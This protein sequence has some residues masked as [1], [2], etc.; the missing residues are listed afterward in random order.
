MKHCHNTANEIDN[1]TKTSCCNRQL[2]NDD[3]R[4]FKC[5]TCC[6]I[7]TSYTTKSKEEKKLVRKINWILMPFIFLLV[8]IQVGQ[9][10]MILQVLTL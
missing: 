2:Q 9:Q 5:A 10:P 3:T 4:H 7:N 8:A 1:G 6:I